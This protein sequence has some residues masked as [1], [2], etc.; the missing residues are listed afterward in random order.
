MSMQALNKYAELLTPNIIE[1]EEGIFIPPKRRRCSIGSVDSLSNAQK[2]KNAI[3]I[4]EDE[5]LFKFPLKYNANFSI[6]EVGKHVLLQPS[7]KSAEAT[8]MAMLLLDLGKKVDLKKLE[9]SDANELALLEGLKYQIKRI[10]N[11]GDLAGLDPGILTV[12]QSSVNAHSFILDALSDKNEAI[13]RDPFHGWMITIAPSA[14]RDLLKDGG[15]FFQL[16]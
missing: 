5:I 10:T 3:F 7:V 11:E 14:F 4:R 2:A 16:I 12:Y 6:T 13:I 1:I 8:C 15:S 9:Y